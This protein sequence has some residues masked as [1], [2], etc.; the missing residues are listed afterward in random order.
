M[1]GKTDCTVRVTLSDDEVIERRRTKS[2]AGSWK[3]YASDGSLKAEKKGFG[4]NIPIEIINAHQMPRIK[5]SDDTT[6]PINVAHQLDGPF[7]LGDTP[8]VR[9]QKID[10]LINT[11]ILSYSIKSLNSKTLENNKNIETHKNTIKETE[12]NL[13]QYKNLDVLKQNIDTINNIVVQIQ[14]KEKELNNVKNLIKDADSSS[15][16]INKAKNELSKLEKINVTENISE[17]KSKVIEFEN[18]YKLLSSV[19]KFDNMINSDKAELSKLDKFKTI[20]IA[21]VRELVDKLFTVTN[22]YE[23]VENILAQIDRIK[24]GIDDSNKILTHQ[25]IHEKDIK[26]DKDE[27]TEEFKQYLKDNN[28]CPTCGMVVDEDHLHNIMEGVN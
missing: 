2:N 7:L 6:A 27:V 26:K 1:T 14:Q 24:C 15:L 8:G 19:D 12:K 28:V 22:D 11:E 10:K 3:V 9:A 21:E 25:I 16:F 18:I 17:F 13:E 23:K 4:S 20:D 5:F